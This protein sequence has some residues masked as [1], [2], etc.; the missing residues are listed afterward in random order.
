MAKTRTS[1]KALQQAQEYE[2]QQ[3]HWRILKKQGIMGGIALTLAVAGA[4]WYFSR[5]QQRTPQIT[6]L[7]NRQAALT[8]ED[9]R[10]HQEKRQ[11]FLDDLLHGYTIPA[12]SG[13][14][15][16]HN[17]EK[18]INYLERETK[19]AKQRTGKTAQEQ[20]IGGER[21]AF[22]E[23]KYDIK[24]PDVLDLSG[25][26]RSVPIFVGRNI[27]EGKDFSYLT[28][29]DLR[30]IIVVHE[31]EH[32]RQHQKGFPYLSKNEI[33]DALE[34]AEITQGMLYE[35]FEYDAYINEIPRLLSENWNVSWYH[36][37]ESKARFIATGLSLTRAGKGA[38]LLQQKIIE[39]LH[40][41]AAQ[42]QLLRNVNV[43]PRWFEEYRRLNAKNSP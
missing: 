36:L 40:F 17:G 11:Q 5:N 7:E 12:C 6:A 16:D 24:T 22:R 10:N 43:D 41:A 31:S 29:N 42:H 15:Y 9:A 20:Y 38:S 37:N 3:Q 26:G 21:E 19:L 27:F 8:L 35:A 32:V 4:R 25:E 30:A 28:E 1:L 18:I 14:I 33:Q 2:K 23:G 13:V 39:K 34:K